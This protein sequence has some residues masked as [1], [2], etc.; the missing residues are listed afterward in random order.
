[1]VEENDN[2]PGGMKTRQT[3]ALDNCRADGDHDIDQAGI[4][5][6]TALDLLLAADSGRQIVRKLCPVDEGAGKYDV[7]EAADDEGQQP[8][9]VLISEL[10]YVLHA[11]RPRLL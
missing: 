6:G 11:S 9:L 8:R 7:P 3:V 4:G 10:A 2:T 5:V 1:M